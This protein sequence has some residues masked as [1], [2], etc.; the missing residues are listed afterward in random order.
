M[1]TVQ[2]HIADRQVV[3]S[4]HPLF[5][6]LR[7]NAPL[8]GVLPVVSQLSFWVLTF[9]DVLR[10]NEARVCE[11]RLRRI[12]RHH[13]AEDAGHEQWFLHDLMEIDGQLPDARALFSSAHAAV[14]D[15]SFALASEVFRATSD[16]E[17]ITLLLALESTGHVFFEAFAAYVERM[18]LSRSLQYLSRHHADVERHHEVFEAKQQAALD[19]M[20]PPA[21]VRAACVALVDRVFEA[22]NAMFDHLESVCARE[23]ARPSAASRRLAERLRPHGPARLHP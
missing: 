2:A 11:P 5:S 12:A 19:A 10:L 15:A 6:R 9:Q 8:R 3:L 17:R 1:R 13:R 4:V 23:A 14:R 20:D 7:R 22:F 16:L 18:G 21:E